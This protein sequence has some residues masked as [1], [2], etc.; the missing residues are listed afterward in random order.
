MG[1]GASAPPRSAG[2][3]EVNAGTRWLRAEV[4]PGCRSLPGGR[5]AGLAAP[6]GF[7][8]GG[9]GPGLAAL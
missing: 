2:K 8:G 9:G 5:K 6:Y 7:L 4:G 3:V 1:P